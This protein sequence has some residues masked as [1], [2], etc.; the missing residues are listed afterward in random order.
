MG[1]SASALGIQIV[2]VQ[3]KETHLVG[4]VVTLADQSRGTLG[5]MPQAA[6]QNAAFAGTLV[7]A[8]QEDR[9]VGYALYGLPR[10]IVR[11]THLCVADDA[12]GQGVARLLA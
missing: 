1:T 2:R 12:R 6:F 3:P 7:A 5:F 10:Q 8:I 4:E 9:V 11:L